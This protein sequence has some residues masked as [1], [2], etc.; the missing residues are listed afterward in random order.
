MIFVSIINELT[1]GVDGIEMCA[2]SWF[3]SL[4]QVL[5]IGV[6]GIEVC[7]GSDHFNDDPRILPR[8]RRRTGEYLIGATLVGEVNMQA[9]ARQRC[10][11]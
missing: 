4:K 6:D 8:Q 5:T 11:R 2:L 1:V 3:R 7:A 10:M 9:H